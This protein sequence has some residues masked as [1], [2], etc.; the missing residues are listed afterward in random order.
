MVFPPVPGV[1][2]WNNEMTKDFYTQVEE[3]MS[4]MDVDVYRM[5]EDAE[6][7]TI[8]IWITMHVHWKKELGIEPYVGT[9]VWGLEFT[10]DQEQVS[11]FVE[12]VDNAATPIIWEKYCK[13]Q[14][15]LGLPPLTL[16]GQE[17]ETN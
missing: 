9:Y 4:H 1:K 10:E 15:I 7:N 5:I 16:P 8:D 2:P 12:H 13:G 11:K 17:T 14:E 6:Q 3:M